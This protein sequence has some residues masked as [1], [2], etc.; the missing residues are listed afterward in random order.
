MSDAYM[1]DRTG[2]PDLDEV[3]LE[4]ELGRFGLRHTDHTFSGRNLQ[5][6]QARRLLASGWPLALAAAIV[7][8]I[9]GLVAGFSMAERGRTLTP[10]PEVVAAPPAV[11]GSRAAAGSPTAVAPGDAGTLIRPGSA[12][13]VPTPTPTPIPAPTSAPAVNP[14][15]P[16][17]KPRSAPP[18]PKRP[19]GIIDP[20]TG[21][22]P[23]KAKRAGLS[24]REVRQVISRH[25]ASVKRRCWG[26]SDS[27]GAGTVR[28]VVSL[29]I[30]PNGAVDRVTATSTGDDAIR[31]KVARCVAS[32]VE[33]WTFPEASKKTTVNVPIVFAPKKR[34]I[35]PFL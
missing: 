13:I 24:S 22:P 7:F 27:S 31:G 14:Y 32:Q 18:A 1:W 3:R 25:T 11:V 26:P 4:A 8:G 10:Q 21:P 30:S 33:R 17:S 9:G 34:L 6:R 35:D 5:R 19:S 15:L 2:I 12:V 20:W 28:V 23:G 29:T 16:P